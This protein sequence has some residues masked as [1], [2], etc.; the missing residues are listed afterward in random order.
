MRFSSSV[1]R[2]VA[3]AASACGSSHATDAGTPDAGCG[4]GHVYCSPAFGA[5]CT[6]SSYDAVCADGAWSCDSPPEG[7]GDDPNLVSTSAVGTRWA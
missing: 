1:F 5:C 2:A 3:L 7:F 6:D 4:G